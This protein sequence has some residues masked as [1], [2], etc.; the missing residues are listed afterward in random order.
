MVGRSLCGGGEVDVSVVL[1]TVQETGTNKKQQAKSEVVRKVTAAAEVECRRVV[2][3]R[4]KGER[5]C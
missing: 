4:L 1:F 2:R 5:A 3:A